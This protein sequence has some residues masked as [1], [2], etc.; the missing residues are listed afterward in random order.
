MKI[1]DMSDINNITVVAFVNSNGNIVNS[2]GFGEHLT[3]SPKDETIVAV[4]NA[5]GDLSH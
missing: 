3:F 5:S 1:V 2:T 4:T